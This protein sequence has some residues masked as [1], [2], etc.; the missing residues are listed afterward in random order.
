MP[1]RTPLTQTLA[2]VGAA[3]R[4]A[5][6]VVL[7]W[8]TAMIRRL[9]VPGL[10]W[11]SVLLAAATMTLLG[12]VLQA[13]GNPQR[14]ANLVT[15]AWALTLPAA[16]FGFAFELRRAKHDDSDPAGL[17]AHSDAS[18]VDSAI[19]PSGVGGSAPR[20]PLAPPGQPSPGQ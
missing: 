15:A 11:R 9:S 2:Q 17:P 14:S 7:G 13:T 8:L 10:I 19:A 6:G 3:L 12:G 4:R 1:T 16:L 18:S 20:L 5:L